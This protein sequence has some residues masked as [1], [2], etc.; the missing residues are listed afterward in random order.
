M[1]PVIAR[2]VRLVHTTQIIQQR[3]RSIM[4]DHAVHRWQNARCLRGRVI[5]EIFTVVVR[6]GHAAVKVMYTILGTRMKPKKKKKIAKPRI[7]LT[8]PEHVAGT[9]IVHHIVRIQKHAIIQVVAV[10]HR[11][12]RHVP[13]QPVVQPVMV[14]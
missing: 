12:Y 5:Q 6:V 7:F 9:D 2:Q 13:V 4:A 1:I 3:A 8:A 14:L 11:V 10:V